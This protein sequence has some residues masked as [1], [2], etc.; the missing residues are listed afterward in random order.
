MTETLHTVFETLPRLNRKSLCQNMSI[1]WAGVLQGIVIAHFLRFNTAMK[2]VL[3]QTSLLHDPRLINH[4][5][6]WYKILSHMM[7]HSKSLIS[8]IYAGPE[9][10]FFFQ[11]MLFLRC[12]TSMT[13]ELQAHIIEA[14]LIPCVLKTG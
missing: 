4:I 13:A 9:F 2:A 10:W 12:H 3:S 11:I 7:N 6:K 1:P 5:Q 8:I 14:C